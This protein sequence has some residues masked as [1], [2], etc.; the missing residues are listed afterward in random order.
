MQNIVILGTGGTIAGTAASAHDNLGYQAAQLSVASLLAAVPA[1]HG[2]PLQ[3]EQVAQI[4]SKDMSWA[5]WQLLARRVAD[6]LARQDVAGIV[7]THGTDTLEETAYFLHRVLAPSKPV[8]L[9]AAMRPAT[10]AHADG[11]QNLLDAVTL[12]RHPGA[13][14]VLVVMAGT[15]FSGANIRKIDTQRLD[16]FQVGAEAALGRVHGGQVQLDRPWPVQDADSGPIGLS[17]I[18]T[19]VRNWPRVEIVMNYAGADG[20]LLDALVAQGVQGLVLAGTGNGTL[21]AELQAAAMRAQ[22]AGVQVIRASRCATGPVVGGA[23]GG[24][25]LLPSSGALSAVQARV[26]LLLTLLQRRR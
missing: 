10:S 15:V 5:I 12:A 13:Q 17:T 16:A 26:A 4:D 20:R 14:G 18:S 23:A 21:S 22:A 8:V 25:D 9:T 24:E 6:H 2:L 1:L 7:I 3:A 19:D 11:P